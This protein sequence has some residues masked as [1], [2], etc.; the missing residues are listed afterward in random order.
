MSPHRE[1]LHLCS[2]VPQLL[3]ERETIYWGGRS[4]VELG[5]RLLVLVWAWARSLFATR[6]ACNG[7]EQGAGVGVGVERQTG[8][9]RW[10]L[11]DAR[12]RDRE[13]QVEVA[14]PP[15]RLATL[16]VHSNC[17]SHSDSN[18]SWSWSS[19]WKQLFR[20]PVS[21]GGCQSCWLAEILWF[22]SKEL[23][24]RD[25]YE[26]WGSQTRSNTQSWEWASNRIAE[27]WL[28]RVSV[29]VSKRRALSVVSRPTQDY[30]RS[31]GLVG[32]ALSRLLFSSRLARSSA[33]RL[34]IAAC[35]LQSAV[36]SRQ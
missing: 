4:L 29:S 35:G 36:G 1:S 33:C 8:V 9:G 26:S 5:Q 15:A 23:T 3:V 21:V 32:C 14:S 25:Y 28:E 13:V 16:L 24:E 2:Q 17:D 7:E 20:Q 12:E 27:S 18:L 6:R 30:Y 11:K 10:R 31:H 22:S 34:E 19:S